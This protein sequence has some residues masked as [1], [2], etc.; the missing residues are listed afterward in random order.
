[1]LQCLQNVVVEIMANKIFWAIKKWW[2]DVLGT[3]QYRR[4]HDKDDRW[5]RLTGQFLSLIT[6]ILGM[7]YLVW[8]WQHI[9]WDVWYYSFVFFL[10]ELTGL[11]L[12]SFF[13][14]DAWSLRYQAP[15]GIAFERTFS[16]DVFIPVAGEPLELVRQTIEAALR[17][18]FQNKRVYILDDK[19]DE[20]IKKLA[21]NSGCSYFARK[22]HSDAKAGNMNYAFHRTDGDLILAL[23][24]DQVPHSQIINKLIGYFKIPKIAFVQTKQDFKV[25]VGDPFGN[26]DRIFY[27]A[28]QSGKD[29]DNA[30]FSCGSGVVYQRAALQEIGGFS[31][32]NL[33]EDVHTSM[34]LHKRGWRSVYYNYPLT[35][36]TAPIDIRNVYRQRRQWAADS[37]RML[38]WDNPFRQT[39]LTFKQKLQYSNLG[40]VY[41][42]SAFVMPIFFITPIWALLTEHFIITAPVRDYVL[43]RFPYFISMSVAYFI[44]NYP[45]PYMKAY[46]MW[47]GLFPV[48]IQATW[49][50]LRSRKKKPPYR[51]NIKNVGQVKA[52]SPW[53]SISPQLGIILLSMF[54]I[55]YIFIV[56]CIAWDFYLLN[57]IWALWSI[58][59]MS[60]ICLAAITKHECPI[61]SVSEEISRPTSFFSKIREITLMVILSI[62]VIVFFTSL[63]A[64]NINRFMSRLRLGVLQTL[65]LEKPNVPIGNVIS[66]TSRNWSTPDRFSKEQ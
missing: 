23:D 60:G 16:V 13:A 35:R 17:I 34:L 10:A 18:D 28:M 63:D 2:S 19:E 58:W 37:L 1:M 15:E 45:T 22:D 43:N 32:W 51:V 59:T 8:H 3:R 46:Q 55:I 65:R 52:K 33:V 50:A 38:F 36:G 9:N 27:N 54:A 14:F 29:N 40:F 62:L 7:I 25:P 5:R 21:E 47:S 20:E 11:V 44:L 41:L 42:V 6:I 31:T 53:V 24:A 64:S 12:F 61:E 4:Y 66:E 48:F 56:G 30:A 39:G 26:A 49:I 57:F